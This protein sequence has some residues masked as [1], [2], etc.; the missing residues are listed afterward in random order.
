[1]KLLVDSEI[2]FLSRANELI[3]PFEENNLTPNGYDLTVGSMEFFAKKPTNYRSSP[4]PINSNFVIYTKEYI[5]LT[6]NMVAQLFLKSSLCCKGVM[7]TFGF[8]DA[9]FEGQ[10]RLGM[11]NASGA[12]LELSVGD[13]VCQ[14]IFYDLDRKPKRDYAHRS[15]NFH[16]FRKDR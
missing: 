8:V 4:M 6:D 16:R 5:K 12:P 15:G 9:G 10:L 11:F 3:K 1:M 2:D 13:K 14:I 7:A